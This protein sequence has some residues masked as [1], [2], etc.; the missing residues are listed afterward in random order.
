MYL[1][2]AADKKKRKPKLFSFTELFQVDTGAVKIRFSRA[3]TDCLT[4]AI[5]HRE[6]TRTWL[7]LLSELRN[8]CTVLS[9]ESDLGH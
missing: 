2:A 9:I 4:L 6:S 7:E 5:Q 8:P 1:A 3:L